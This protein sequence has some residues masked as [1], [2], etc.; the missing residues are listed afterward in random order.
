MVYGLI[1]MNT[2]LHNTISVMFPTK[3]TMWS[4]D[5]IRG[6]LLLTGDQNKS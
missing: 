1:A 5:Y 4:H 6:N 2:L 3:D